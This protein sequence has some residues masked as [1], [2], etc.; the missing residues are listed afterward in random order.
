MLTLDVVGCR[1]GGPE[2]WLTARHRDWQKDVA[3]ERGDGT[4]RMKDNAG[5]IDVD[6]AIRRGQKWV[7]YPSMALLFVPLTAFVVVA[8]RMGDAEISGW[9]GAA[10]V[11]TPIAASWLWWSVMLPRWRVW[12]IEHVDDL[13]ELLLQAMSKQ[14]MWAPGSFFER[15]E[16]QSP[17]L[18][19]RLQRALR[20]SLARYAE[21]QP[22]DEA[23]LR[24]FIVP[25]LYPG[26]QRRSA[27]SRGTGG[28]LTLILGVAAL[29]I[30]VAGTVGHFLYGSPMSRSGTA[31]VAGTGVLLTLWGYRSAGAQSFSFAVSMFMMFLGLSLGGGVLRSYP[32]RPIELLVLALSVLGGGVGY[33]MTRRRRGG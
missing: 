6:T 21:S 11:V 14:L 27:G 26:R 12:A 8:V 29:V 32:W 17:D 24:A 25:W 3:R 20:R 13:G 10:G 16:I 31:W 23:S 28:Y 19:L 2:R 18:R 5:V 15:T 22:D 1:F 4:R 9:L 30:V 7:S 33:M